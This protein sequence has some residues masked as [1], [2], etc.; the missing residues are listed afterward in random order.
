MKKNK[1]KISQFN[2]KLEVLDKN[3]IKVYLNYVISKYGK[4]FINL[5]EN[6]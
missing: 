1:A 4:D 6:K 3:K 5:Y 2:R